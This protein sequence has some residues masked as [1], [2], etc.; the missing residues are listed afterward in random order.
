MNP[1]PTQPKKRG[2]K[3]RPLR[4]AELWKRFETHILN[5]G[6][7]K[8]RLAKLRTMYISVERG[9]EPGLA[10]ATKEDIERF[11]GKLSR[12][13]YVRQDGKQYSGT[14]KSD[15]KNFLKQFYKWLRGENQYYPKEVAWIKTRISKDERPEE[16]AIVTETEIRTLANN[17]TD[18]RYRMLT[19]LL[20]DSGFRI[21]EMLSVTRDHLTLEKVED[22]GNVWFI[23]CRES[24]TYPRKVDVSLFTEDINNF[25]NSAYVSDKKANDPL[26]DVNYGYYV[27]LLHYH[28]TRLFKKKLTPHSLRHSSATLYASIYRGDS[29]KLA[30]RYGWSY[31]AKQ[32]NTYVRR[33][34]ARQ[35]ESV[36][37]IAANEVEKLRSENEALRLQFKKMQQD[38]TNMMRELK[39]I[40]RSDLLAARRLQK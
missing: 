36:K 9:M 12:N 22:V 2:V 15:M 6:L 3:P 17:F 40:P 7:T 21:G 20:F 38:V 34:G 19:L 13:T 11:V 14:T 28:S 1:P 33:N 35:R 30:E 4:D 37:I 10:K 8:R 27:R 29:I 23:E 25:V 18:A 24:K 32:L 26:F 5:E 39:A 16:K 31:S